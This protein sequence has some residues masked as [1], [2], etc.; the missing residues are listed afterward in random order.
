MTGVGGERW[1][2]LQSRIIDIRDRLDDAIVLAGSLTTLESELNAVSG[3]GSSV[4]GESVATVDRYGVLTDMRLLPTA[5]AGGVEELR[6]A[7]VTA[8]AAAT[9]H[10]RQQTADLTGQVM[11]SVRIVQAPT[12]PGDAVGGTDESADTSTD[13]TDVAIALLERMFTGEE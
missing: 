1:G 7:V 11:A 4:D 3:V 2:E 10:M 8:I 12:R 6:T 13:N 5:L 9:L